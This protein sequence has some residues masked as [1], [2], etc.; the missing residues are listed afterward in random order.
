MQ[1][2]N[3]RLLGLRADTLVEMLVM[4]RALPGRPIPDA[5]IVASSLVADALPLV[6]FD[7]EQR[8]YGIATAEP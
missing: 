2:E 5:M 3:V 1:R 6:T 7:R 4:A 8:R